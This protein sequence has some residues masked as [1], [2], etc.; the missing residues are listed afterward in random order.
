MRPVTASPDAEVIDGRYVLDAV[1]GRGA[2]A[3]VRSGEDLRLGRAVAVKLLHESLA[4]QPEARLRFEEEARAAARLTD[5]NVVAIYDTGEHRGRPYIVMELLPG[6]T[7]RDELGDGPL[8]E[9]RARDVI[10]HVL[11]A[12]QFA[13]AAGVIHRDIKPANILLTQTGE[14]KVADFGIAKVAESSDLTATGLVLG[15]PSYLAPECVTGEAATVA[16]DLYATGVVLYEALSG[17]RPFSGAT[18]LA[19]CHAIT[20]EEPTPLREHA[21]LVSSDLTAVVTRAMAKDPK[22]RYRS[23]DEMIRA[24]DGERVPLVASVDE[25]TQPIDP[26]P[27]VL[28]PSLRTEE[29]AVGT[30]TAASAATPPRGVRAR[31]AAFVVVAALVLGIAAIVSARDDGVDA[32]R[33]PPAVTTNPVGTAPTA[34]VTVAPVT[35]AATVPPPTAPGKDKGKDKK[36]KPG[37]GDGEG[38]PERDD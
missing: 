36:D 2:M 26:E 9:D 38:P 12:L 35:T 20:S 5:P 7:L 14:A 11:H 37:P 27:T 29:L 18:P 28:S 25:A 16:S 17:A 31:V 1:I 32:S 22:A 10:V 21:P 15:T 19:V 3:E 6:R 34:T 13:Y 33:N 8:R 30:A 23:A 24:V 4:S